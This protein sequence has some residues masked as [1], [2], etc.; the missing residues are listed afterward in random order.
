MNDERPGE[1]PA[2]HFH[3]LVKPKTTKREE[4]Q[5]DVSKKAAPENFITVSICL[6]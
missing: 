2:L 4:N 6:A 3:A 5:N 1:G